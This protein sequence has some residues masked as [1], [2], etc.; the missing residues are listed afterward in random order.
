MS[1]NRFISSLAPSIAA[2]MLLFTVFVMGG[3]G[4]DDGSKPV[5]KVPQGQQS[6]K[7]SAA[8]VVNA[9]GGSGDPTRGKLI[10]EKHCHFCHGRKGRGDGP[11]GIAVSPHPADFVKDKKRMRQTDKELYL[12][13][14]DGV[15]KELGGEEMSMPPWKGILSPSEISDVLAY[16]RVL[17]RRPT[18]K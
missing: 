1:F 17:S 8:M 12:S 4:G 5:A 14:R 15:K 9:G 16:I 3:C 18:D 7:A 11:V 2:L 6:A 10:Y 13:I